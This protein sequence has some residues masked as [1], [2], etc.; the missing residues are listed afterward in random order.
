MAN[1]TIYPYGTNG[2]LPSSIGV[3]NDLTTGGADKALSA[4]MGKRLG[5]GLYGEEQSHTQASANGK[6]DITNDVLSPT[7]TSYSHAGSLL[8]PVTA[9][10]VVT[11]GKSSKYS[12]AYVFAATD[13]EYN[14]LF[15]TSDV[16]GSY[17]VTE[18]GYVVVQ[19]WTYDMPVK[20]TIKTPGIIDTK[21]DK[22]EIPALVSEQT[23]LL[24]Y[25]DDIVPLCDFYERGIIKNGALSQNNYNKYSDY[26]RINPST[27][28]IVTKVT[29]NFPNLAVISFYGDQNEP[30]YLSG[31]DII[32]SDIS[33]TGTEV[34]APSAA[35]YMRICF[36]LYATT[37]DSY[38]IQ[39]EVVSLLRHITDKH[40]GFEFILPRYVDG[41][42]GSSVRL[43]TSQFMDYDG[44]YYFRSGG[45]ILR[46]PGHEDVWNLSSETNVILCDKYGGIKAGFTRNADTTIQHFKLG[47]RL[48][49]HSG[50]DG[51]EKTI[52]FIGDSLMANGPSITEA[53]RLL[54][55]DGDYDFHYIS[56]KA[57]GRKYSDYI[58][59][60]SAFYVDGALNF[61][62]YMATKH[63]SIASHGIDYVII[64]LGTNDVYST[65]Y[66]VIVANAKTLIDAILDET[67]GY[68]NAKIAVGLPSLGAPFGST[69]NDTSFT[70][71]Y[72]FKRKMKTLNKRLIA[73]FDNGAY[74]AGVTCM[75]HGAYIYGWES[76]KITDVALNDYCETTGRRFTDTIHPQEKGYRQ[77]GY[78]FY[79]KIR[80]F[81]AGNL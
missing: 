21:A 19:S 76:Y 59:S 36:G 66:D 77:W 16:S 1:Q 52:L 49:A 56:E 43:F 10:Q 33:T 64:A 18:D 60:S 69:N 30:S 72:E 70:N 2:Q 5:N 53:T 45:N 46:V 6:H 35:H 73:E 17:T 44:G 50:G 3:I 40:K 22:E 7:K 78:A 12:L 34:I 20:A 8:L 74:K 39:L 27:K 38:K 65:A 28:M 80:A 61:Q 67:T 58:G 25:T 31:E 79:C 51:S 71:M 29:S 75:A 4:E 54:D 13:S 68:P 37:Y 63:A 32:G 24:K 62:Q 48:N 55:V 26:I 81:L 15:K 42:S 41:V 11:W 9:G 23:E 47:V 57:E 14:V